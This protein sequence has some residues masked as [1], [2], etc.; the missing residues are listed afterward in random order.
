VLYLYGWTL[1]LAALALALRFVPYSD[2]DGTLNAGW[3]VV[4]AAFGLLALAASL[5]LVLVLEIL[6]FRRFRERE[7]RRQVETGEIPAL[8]AEQIE[9]EIE[10]Q[11]ETGEFEALRPPETGEFERVGRG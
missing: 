3:T 4:I 7:I 11:V 9:E 5:Y 10:R 6:K 1:S 8:S 2:D